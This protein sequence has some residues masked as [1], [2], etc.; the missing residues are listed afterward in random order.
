MERKVSVHEKYGLQFVGKK[1]RHQHL[2]NEVE[3]TS[4]LCRDLNSKI[5]IG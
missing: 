3:E 1:M 4:R 5:L 2:F